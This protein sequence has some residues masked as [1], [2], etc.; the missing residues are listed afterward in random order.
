MSFFQQV[1]KPF[2]TEDDEQNHQL[3][4]Q[5]QYYERSIKTMEVP[6]PAYAKFNSQ[7]LFIS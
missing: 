3:V 1:K 2:L 5:Q 4:L 6:I 7:R